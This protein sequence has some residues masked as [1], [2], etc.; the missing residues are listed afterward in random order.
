MQIHHFGFAVKNIE[1]AHE[2]FR[3][4]LGLRGTCEVIYDPVQ[5]V[6]VAFLELGSGLFLELIEPA[7][8]ESPVHG[9]LAKGG[10]LY[11][12]CFLTPDLDAEVARLVNCGFTVVCPPTA[13]TG[14]GNR[15]I[16]FLFDP[17]VRLIELLE[18]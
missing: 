14:F 5:R 2:T 12:A 1:E 3:K 18:N 15:R 16:A 13:A 7:G 10:G 6:R 11:H 8:A 17:Q 4:T 9:F